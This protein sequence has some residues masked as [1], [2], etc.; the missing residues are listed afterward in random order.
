QHNERLEFLGDA[1][2]DLVISERLYELRPDANEGDLSRLR[3]SLVRRESL[4]AIATELQLGDYIRL[5]PGEQRSGGHRRQST[6]ADVL[7]AVIGAVYIDAGFG[8]AS[9][10]IGGL[11]ADRL[12]SLPDAES[13]RDPKTRL[14][15]QLQARGRGLPQYTLEKRSGEDHAQRFEVSCQVTEPAILTRGEGG[16]RR[17]AEQRAAKAALEK[18][19]EMDA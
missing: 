18:L 16:S 4:A 17:R 7:E 8:A 13:L 12:Q 2:L 6:M 11:F 10:L 9:A 1:V 19:L 15:E 3:A 14:Q 5:G